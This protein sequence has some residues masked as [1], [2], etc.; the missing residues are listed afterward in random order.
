M[1]TLAWTVLRQ[2]CGKIFLV[3]FY[4][5]IIILYQN[6]TTAMIFPLI[7]SNLWDMNLLWRNIVLHEPCL[8]MFIV[9]VFYRCKGEWWWV[10]CI[11]GCGWECAAHITHTAHHNGDLGCTNCIPE[12]NVNC[13]AHLTNIFPL[14]WQPDSDG[15]QRSAVYSHLS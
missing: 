5:L 13:N 7:N 3:G 4:K 15:D 11:A 14:F 6:K 1:V 8:S 10:V 12:C 2:F 9:Y